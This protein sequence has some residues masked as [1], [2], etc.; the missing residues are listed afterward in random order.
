MYMY[1][2]I[3]ISIHSLVTFLLFIAGTEGSPPNDGTFRDGKT[4]FRWLV[5]TLSDII[6]Q[7]CDVYFLLSAV[8]L[9]MDCIVHFQTSILK[10]SPQ[11]CEPFVNLMHTLYLC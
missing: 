4:Y 8:R 5:S 2:C 3:E 6:I 11:M 10:Q 9:G 1:M 7:L